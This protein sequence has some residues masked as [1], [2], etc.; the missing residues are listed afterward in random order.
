LWVILNNKPFEL[1]SEEYISNTIKL[2]WKCLIEGCGEIFEANWNHIVG[3]RGCGYC[4]GS[5]VGLSNC[6]ATKS[7][8]LAKEWHPTKNG[9][10]TP[11]NITACSNRSVW[12]RCSENPTHE[13]YIEVNNRFTNNTNCPYCSGRLPTPENNLLV[14]NPKLASEWNYN[15]NDKLP[16]DYCPNSNKFAYWIC[17]ECSHEWSSLIYSRNDG[18]GCPECSKD[19][20]GEMKSQEILSKYDIPSSP[21]LKFED[22]KDKRRLPFDIAS[23]YDKEKTRLKILI[24]YDGYQHFYPVNFGGVSDDIA[25]ENL[26]IT[27][28][29]DLI[30]NEYCIL[31]DIPL[32]RIPY[33]DFDNIEKILVDVFVNGN[34]DSKYFVK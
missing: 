10:L 15:K 2:K 13:W 18:A 28:C 31:N 21:Q 24:E 6:L 8:E 16:E 29:H 30:K 9:D 11:L 19:S 32:L 1:I 5:Q 34:M 14:C 17:K 23:F 26:K 12:W 22:C 25:L 7:P 33:W 3:N 4:T 27:Q 20:K